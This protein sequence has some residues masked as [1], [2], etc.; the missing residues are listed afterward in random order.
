MKAEIIAPLRERQDF[1]PGQELCEGTVGERREIYG[2]HEIA[3]RMKTRW[4]GRSIRFFEET[5]STN[6]R[7]RIEGEQGAAHG[8]LV[9]ADMQTAGL[10][11]RG[12]S[13]SSPAGKNIYFTLLLRPDIPP[14]K[15]SMLTLVMAHAVVVGIGIPDAGIKWPNDI[16]IDGRKVC[17][18]L[19]EMN[20]SVEQASISY[21]VV[22][23]GINVLRQDFGN[24][25][26]GRAVSLEEACGKRLDRSGLI[27]DI[28]QAFESD[29]D[30]FLSCQDLSG[31]QESYNAML[32]NRGREV[33]V[34]DPAGEYRGIARGINASGELLVE[35]P[36]GAVNRVYAGEVSVRGIYGYV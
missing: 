14:E 11:R 19:T 24:G 27:A 23:V 28:M 32:V 13:W 25:I 3:S 7:A 34:L 10:G 31:L 17:G 1:V 6:A 16:V 15:A 30:N 36:D 33:C 5:D 22:G 29:Y 20:M 12:R 35:L 4:I 26:S 9:V 2:Q 21:V 8:T 18:I